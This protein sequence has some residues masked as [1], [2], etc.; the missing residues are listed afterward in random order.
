MA[1]FRTPLVATSEAPQHPDEGLSTLELDVH[2]VDYGNQIKHLV[3]S[4]AELE[5]FMRENGHDKDLRDAVGENIVVIA[6]KRAE[7]GSLQALRA[8]RGDV[9]EDAAAPDA[10][11]APTDANAPR[12]AAGPE[13]PPHMRPKKRPA[14]P[15][16]PP[17][18]TGRESRAPTSPQL[19]AAAAATGAVGTNGAVYL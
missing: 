9:P 4:N 12:I 19:G 6:R 14:G 8:R 16:L 13:L 3:R 17:H 5:E 15:E 1:T 11:Y 18:M 2:I 7:L 10:A